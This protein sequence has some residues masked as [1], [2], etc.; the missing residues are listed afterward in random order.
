M[1]GS[2]QITET[3]KPIPGAGYYEASDRGHV[4]SIDRTIDGRFYKGVVLK[5]REDGDGYLVVN[6]TMDDRTRKHGASVAR[7]VLL[8]FDPDGYREGLQACHGPGGQKDNS[9]LNLRWDTDEANRQEAL[10]VRLAN[11]PPKP[12]P[13]KVCPRCKREHGGK[14]Q[15]CHECVVGLGVSAALMLANGVPLDQVSARLDYPPAGLFNLAVRYG[16]ARVV[17]VQA[18]VMRSE[19]DSGHAPSRKPWLRSVLIRAQTW[20]ADSDAE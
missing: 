2:D 5:L 18:K 11:H 12:K 14:G 19:P 17:I 1:T 4:R 16:G 13:V 9:V 7:L 10:Q 15:N 3:W 6:I 20:L 8:T